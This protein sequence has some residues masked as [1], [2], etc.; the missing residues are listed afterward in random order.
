MSG[1]HRDLQ[2]TKESVMRAVTVTSDCL[3][4]MRTTLPSIRF[5]RERIEDSIRNDTM[6]THAALRMTLEGRSFRDA[7]RAAAAESVAD[8]ET[9]D[10]EPRGNLT[11]RDALAAYRTKGS[12]GHGDPDA[13]RDRVSNVIAKL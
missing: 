4:A 8:S 1:Y 12:P 7:Y 9:D 5:D 11:P 10:N 13:L 2:L 3:T 6:A